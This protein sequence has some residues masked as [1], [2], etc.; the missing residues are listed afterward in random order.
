MRTQPKDTNMNADR[1]KGLF[2]DPLEAH[3]AYLE[4]KGRL[5]GFNPNINPRRAAL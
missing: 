5:H 2:Q 3:Q 4:A 1:L